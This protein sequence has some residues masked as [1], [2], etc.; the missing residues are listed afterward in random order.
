[1]KVKNNPIKHWTDGNGW[2]MAK[3]MHDVVLTS[4]KA[5]TQVANYFS[6]N[7]NEVTTLDNQ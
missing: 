1:L 3:I 4:T 7:A 2:G 6:M 5:I